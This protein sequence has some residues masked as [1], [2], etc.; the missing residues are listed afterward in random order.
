MGEYFKGRSAFYGCD[1]FY[2]FGILIFRSPFGE[3]IG[4]IGRDVPFR[5]TVTLCYGT[6]L[7]CWDFSWF[8][9]SFRGIH[10]SDSFGDTG[11][12]VSATR[13]RY[14]DFSYSSS[15]IP[16]KQRS[17]HPCV[18]D[19]VVRISSDRGSLPLW[20]YYSILFL[21]CQEV[22]CIFLYLVYKCCKNLLL[23]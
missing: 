4:F 3:T 17:R 9:F 16:R 10:G 20:L 22:F 2:F 7:R 1:P 14:S 8:W 15:P 19:A 12:L 21:C 11:H 13:I 5:D 6:Q 23:F 18:L